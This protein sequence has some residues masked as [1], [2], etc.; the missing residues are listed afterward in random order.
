MCEKFHEFRPGT[1]FVAWA[2]QIAWW[3][4]RGARQRL[5]R[6]RVLFVQDVLDLPPDVAKEVS[7]SAAPAIPVI[8]VF[9]ESLDF[10]IGYSARSTLADG[11]MRNLP[12]VVTGLIA[13]NVVP[14]YPA[15]SYM[16][17]FFD[18]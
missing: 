3:R 14:P 8:V 16:T 7:H 11:A 1:D 2:C 15:Q 13:L 18:E 17:G 9:R 5:A 6:S 12:K 4:V 10:E